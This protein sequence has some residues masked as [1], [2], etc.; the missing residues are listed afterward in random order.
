MRK[1][2][3]KNIKRYKFFF[4]LLIVSLALMVYDF[5]LG[6]NSFRLTGVNMLEMLSILPP[7]FILLGLLDVW[8]DKALMIKLTGKGSGIRGAV[9]AFLLGSLAAGPLYAAF[10]IAG[11]MLKKES[12][13]SNVIIF[14]GAWSTTKVPML[15]FEASSMGLKFMLLRFLLNLPVIVLI[16]L[17]TEKVLS[18]EEKQV[19]YENAERMS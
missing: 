8:V 2:V 3:R 17:I 16:A 11:V 7:V 5:K 13:F 10:P 15:M 14:I 19:I 12:K 4:I 1:T 9:I 18:Q 6:M